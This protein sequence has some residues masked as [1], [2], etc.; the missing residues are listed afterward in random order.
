MKSKYEKIVLILT[1]LSSSLMATVSQKYIL[2]VLHFNFPFLLLL[3]QS[4]IVIF[5]IQIL[6][7]FGLISLKLDISKFKT[8]LPC[9]LALIFMIYTG[10][11]SLYYLPIS[12][13]SLFKNGSIILI[14]VLEK[15]LFKRKIDKNSY[16]A[17]ILMII[18]SGFVDIGD[19][20]KDQLGYLWILLNIISTTLYLMSL[21]YIL[22]L[23]GDSN[24]E[25]L[26]YGQVLL[27]PFLCTLS[28]FYKIDLK[29]FDTVLIFFI[30]LS[31]ISIFFVTYSSIWCIRLLSSTTFSMLGAMNKLFVSFSGI[32]LIGENNIDFLKIFSLIL[33]FVASII[34]SKTIKNE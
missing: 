16:I 24:F 11:K 20:K 19:F 29:I 27:I 17:F 7:F 9:S 25:A 21:K 8:W 30:L 13:Y 4:I 26:F 31:G 1:Y 14:A 3:I 23:T 32:L 12:V 6:V 28:F 5:M 10:I 34:Y 2:N 33:G 18:S 22:T 15:Q